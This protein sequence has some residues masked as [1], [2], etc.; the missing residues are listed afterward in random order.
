[1]SRF[2]EVLLCLLLGI[3]AGFCIDLRP[4]LVQNATLNESLSKP[5]PL[6][7]NESEIS[8]NQDRGE[9]SC[10]SMECK[11]SAARI[12]ASMD[13]SV[14]PCDDF[15]Q[16][17]CGGFMKQHPVSGSSI[18]IFDQVF[19]LDSSFDSLKE[20]LIKILGNDSSLEKA[21]NYLV[22]CAK[23]K[24]ESLSDIDEDTRNRCVKETIYKY[25]WILGAAQGV[26]QDGKLRAIGNMLYAVNSAFAKIVNGSKWMDETSKNASIDKVEDVTALIGN[27]PWIFVYDEPPEKFRRSINPLATNAF[28]AFEKNAIPVLTAIL[29]PPLFGMGLDVLDYGAMGS[30]LGH[31]L[32]RSYAMYHYD[33][34]GKPNLLWTQDTAANFMKVK[35]CFVAQYEKEFKDFITIRKNETRDV[36][37]TSTVNENIADNS[38]L[39]AAFRAYK[40]RRPV[41]KIQILKGLESYTPDQLFFLAYANALCSSETVEFTESTILSK[42]TGLSPFRFRVNVPLKNSQLFAKAWKFNNFKLILHQSPLHFK[43]SKSGPGKRFM[44]CDYATRRNALLGGTVSTYLTLNLEAF[45]NGHMR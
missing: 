7:L 18:S 1:M 8:K 26:E 44:S 21:R 45:I 35:E 16:F 2:V 27:E 15:F 9:T 43:I 5:L 31:E 6:P 42:K 41:P 39:T 12:Q 3:V 34:F 24:I 17:S 19:S 4:L 11:Q 10:D 33:K 23:T 22:H 28:Y 30:V 25:K 38:G 20:N 32:A 37:G 13:L 40:R 29:N 36:D 14:D